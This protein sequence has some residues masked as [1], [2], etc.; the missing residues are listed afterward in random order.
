[1]FSEFFGSIVAAIVVEPLQAEINEKIEQARLPVAVIQQSKACIASQGPKLLER[2]T[3]DW[4]WAATAAVSV[5]V[6]FTSPLDVL[7]PNDAQCASF[8]RALKG[9]EGGA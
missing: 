9:A 8:L 6:G 2:A 3:N 7:D 1:M 4:G 5:S